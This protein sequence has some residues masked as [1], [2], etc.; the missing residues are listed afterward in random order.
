MPGL[1]LLQDLPLCIKNMTMTGLS[2]SIIRQYYL[3]KNSAPGLK[4]LTEPKSFA[5]AFEEYS[6]LLASMMSNKIIFTTIGAALAPSMA[7]L[8]I[9]YTRHEQIYY[10]YLMLLIVGGLAGFLLG[11]MRDRRTKL[12]SDPKKGSG[13]KGAHRRVANTEPSLYFGNSNSL[14]FHLPECHRAKKL[15][16]RM[17]FTSRERAI[18]L[19]YSPCKLCDP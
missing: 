14:T 2:L 6:E 16:N 5:T 1:M 11:L 10:G 12:T 8:A 18:N 15:R 19:G 17:I 4:E 13:Q 9:H 3:S 7:Y